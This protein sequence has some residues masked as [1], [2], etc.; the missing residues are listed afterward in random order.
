MSEETK[1]VEPQLALAALKN[2]IGTVQFRFSEEKYLQD[3]LQVI[4]QREAVVFWREHNLSFR[5]RP[6]FFLPFS[7]I[8]IEVKVN[9]ATSAVLRQLE[10]YATHDEVKAILLITTRL[11]HQMPEQLNGKPVAVVTI[12]GL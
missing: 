5:D 1:A 3:G 11:R 9:G 4:F 7:G 10:R 12:L 6:D 8:A 2:L